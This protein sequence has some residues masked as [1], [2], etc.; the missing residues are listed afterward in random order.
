MNSKP[1]SEE[2]KRK[3]SESRKGF[4]VSEETKLKISRTTKGRKKKP[5]SKE[6]RLKMSLSHI[7]KRTGKNSNL[8]K[9]GVTSLRAR[10]RQSIK[11]ISWRSGVLNRDCFTCRICNQI[12]GKLQVDHFPVSFS[13]L[14]D[15]Y[16]INNFE[17]AMV[18][19][20]LWDME[21]GRTL[22]FNCHK[23]TD[24]YLKY[25]KQKIRV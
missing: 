16:D 11:Y 2:A 22:C 18:F 15:D 10:I 7:G 13:K 21:N 1:H 14:F 24:N 23:L 20:K 6:S 8:W 4:K 12:G 5:V 19:D 25:G 9:G 17:D 3:I